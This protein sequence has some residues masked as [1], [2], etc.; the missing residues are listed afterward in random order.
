MDTPDC[1]TIYLLS[2]EMQ[3]HIFT[4]LGSLPGTAE[5]TPHLQGSLG[6]R[7]ACGKRTSVWIALPPITGRSLRDP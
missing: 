4:V 6:V 3:D 2:L 7:H 5:G 1:E